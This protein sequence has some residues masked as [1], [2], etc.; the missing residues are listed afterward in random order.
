[1]TAAVI[2]WVKQSNGRA[3]GALF[4]LAAPLAPDDVG[5]RTVE[6]LELECLAGGGLLLWRADLDDVVAALVD[7]AADSD[8]AW[9]SV[10]ALAGGSPEGCSWWTFE[11]V[12]SWFYRNDRDLGVVCLRP[13]G[14][15]MAVVAATDS[16]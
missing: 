1:M 14:Y 7:A 12:N 10:A 15:V 13:G 11:A 6:A 8:A 3:E 2:G 9:R 5:I 4:T 16:D